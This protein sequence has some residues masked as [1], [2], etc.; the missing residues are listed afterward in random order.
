[1]GASVPLKNALEPAQDART[2]FNILASGCGIYDLS[3]HAKIALTGEDRVRWLNGMI[4]N[5]VRDLAIGRGIYGF[6]LNPQGRI[7]GDL[8]AYNRDEYLLVDTE[9]SQLARVLEIFERYIIM[10]DVVVENISGNLSAIGIAGPKAQEI[11]QAAGLYHPNMDELQFS[12]LTWR[13]A[14]PTLV[15]KDSPTIPVF[16]LW[17]APANFQALWTALSDAGA[18]PVSKDA[19]ELLRIASGL[20]RYG[21]DIRDRDLPQETEQQRALN[22]NKGCYIGQEIVERIRSRG[23]VHRTF[24]GF[25]VEGALPPVGT[26]IFP[27]DKEAK[28]VGEITSVVSSPSATGERGFALGYIR[29]EAAAGDLRAGESKVTVAPLPFKELFKQ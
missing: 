5:N 17:A 15:R 16:E 6:L 22:F 4:T 25:L 28:E 23:L 9:S 10:D 29:R 14:G 3:L 7:L 11:L 18:T 20:P 2:G 12:D 27:A 26:K 1:M 21:V 19:L 13:D 24:T 8:Y